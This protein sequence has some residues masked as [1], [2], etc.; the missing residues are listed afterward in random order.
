MM[1][2]GATAVYTPRHVQAAALAGL[3]GGLVAPLGNIN[4]HM[5]HNVIVTAFID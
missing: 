5:G 1:L 3:A 2:Q 4:P